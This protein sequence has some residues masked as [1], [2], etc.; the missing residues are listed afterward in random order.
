MIKVLED[1]RITYQRTHWVVPVEYNGNKYMLVCDEDDNGAEHG[2]YTYDEGC[3]YNIGE[4][5][6]ENDYEELYEKIIQTMID[7]GVFYSAVEKGT[8]VDE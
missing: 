4:E 3:R 7:A 6:N 8:I 1:A 5:Y 2:I